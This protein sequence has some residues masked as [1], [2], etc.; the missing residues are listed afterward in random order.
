M[1]DSP[2]M[3]ALRDELFARGGV[4]DDWNVIL[5]D[6]IPYS[7][8]APHTDES[9]EDPM[10]RAK[11]V[12]SVGKLMEYDCVDSHWR[13]Q[14]KAVV[15]L[16]EFEDDAKGLVRAIHLS[17]SDG[18]YQHYADEKLG[19]EACVYHLC[20]GKNKS[21]RVRLPRSDHRELIHVANWRMVNPGILVGMEWS[22]PVGVSRIR[23]GVHRFVP[24]PV[25]PPAPA[26]SAAPVGGGTGLDAA[27]KAVDEKGPERSK[28]RS[29]LEKG[30]EV[31]SSSSKKS[32]GRVLHDKSS[33]VVER[34][35]NE[36]MRKKKRTRAK[37][38]RGG[39]KKKK[40]K[41]EDSS[42]EESSPEV[43]ESSEESVFQKPL[44]RGGVDLHRLSKKYPGKLMKSGLEEMGR[45][46]ADRIGEAGEEVPW[47]QRRVMAYINQIM[48]AGGQGAGVGV[49]NQREAMTLGGALDLLLSG[50]LASLG[51]LLMQRLKALETAMQDQNWQAARHQELIAPQM[52]SL[53]TVAEKE[54]A[55]KSELRQQKLRQSM[56]KKVAK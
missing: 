37:S 44:T 1:T 42:S 38:S 30:D 56:M 21:C 14:G 50:S 6:N 32:V 10:V 31:E 54:S 15:E 22:K 3:E 33:V 26:V 8:L 48:M 36:R 13:P 16:V 52:A 4:E 39:R 27:L 34:E 53:S 47:H 20:H 40:S 9:K 46:L 51:D 45:Y 35:E 55:G 23:D 24:H 12:M 5:G 17:A 7:S 18:Y 2:A 25:L 19:V 28:K 11:A 29:P 41:H 49:R 43:E